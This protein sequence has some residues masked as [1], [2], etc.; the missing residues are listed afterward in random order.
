MIFNNTTKMK[1]TH[2]LSLILFASIVWIFSNCASSSKI[3]SYIGRWDYVV[4]TPQGSQ[5]GWIV[6]TLTDDILTGTLNSDMGSIEL[7]D[8]TVEENVLSATFFAFDMD[9]DLSGTFVENEFQGMFMV[10][11]YELPFTATKSEQ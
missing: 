6:L 9:M 7:E 8:L 11:G 5:A 3:P 10:Q 1:K 2:I 4:D